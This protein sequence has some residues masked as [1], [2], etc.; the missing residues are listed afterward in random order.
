MT[1]T[2]EELGARLRG[3]G[4]CALSDALDA[5]GLEQVVHGV[6]GL[7]MPETSYAGRAVTVRLGPTT[8][9]TTSSHLGADAVDHAGPG[10]V[11]VVAN[12]GRTECAAWGGLLSTAAARN[13][14]AGVVVDGAVRDV[15]E[16]RSAGL[17]VHGIRATPVTAR[18]RVAQ[19]SWNEQVLL[20]GVP[21]RPGDW[22]VADESGVI[23]IPADRLDEVIV[24]AD[25]IAGTEARLAE[26]IRAGRA[27]IDV[28]N[29]RYELMLTSGDAR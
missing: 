15:D 8:E 13:G 27:V 22:V 1:P 9:T 16:A 24:V 2:P 26:E 19:I 21:V 3:L 23:V 17:P 28:M 25:R 7:T 20:A 18:G 11:I 12:D 6:S 14:V 29:S 10:E 5:L 4:S